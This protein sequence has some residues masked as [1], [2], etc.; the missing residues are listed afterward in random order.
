MHDPINLNPMMIRPPAPDTSLRSIPLAYTIEGAFTSYFADKPVPVA[1]MKDKK[2]S[3]NDTPEEGDK[4]KEKEK[5]EEKPAID[6]GMVK[7]EE[8]KME[9]GKP[10][11]LFI[12][13]TSY[14][15]DNSVISPDGGNVNSI[16]I[17]N[18]IDYLN[19][20]EETAVMRSKTGSLNPLS[21]VT[22]WAKSGFKFFNIIGL[23]VIVA[24]FGLLIW[25]LR[26]RRKLAIQEAFKKPVNMELKE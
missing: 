17:M 21:P 14:L 2:E 11:K 10:G 1:I 22:P 16:F 9:K 18:L 25:G 24:L 8:K 26:H 7:S 6:S 4:A 5:R 23:P 3:K 19:G 12:A 20:R 15:L 13:G